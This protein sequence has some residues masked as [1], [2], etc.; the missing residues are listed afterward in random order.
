MFYYGC[1]ATAFRNKNK[2]SPRITRIFTKK[3]LK[4]TLIDFKLVLISV[5][6]G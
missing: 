2:N 1:R 3:R 6:R 4:S 5:I